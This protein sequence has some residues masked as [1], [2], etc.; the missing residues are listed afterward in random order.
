MGRELIVVLLIFCVL[1]L[2]LTH[3][4]TFS[5]SYPYSAL[6]LNTSQ[7]I[8]LNLSPYSN[9]TFS[10]VNCMGITTGPSY[11]INNLNSSVLTNITVNISLTESFVPGQY[12]EVIQYFKETLPGELIISQDLVGNITFL[13][14]IYNETPPVSKSKIVFMNP[15]N[16]ALY[17]IN[18]A[19]PL[20]I[21]F[22]HDTPINFSLT[23]VVLFL[24]GE[25]VNY[26][27]LSYSAA[28]KR[29]TV[30][31]LERLPEGI[32]T[33]YIIIADSDN[34]KAQPF[35]FKITVDRT[36]PLYPLS[37]S[38]NNQVFTNQHIDLVVTHNSTEYE[39]WYLI[40]R[41]R[42]VSALDTRWIL[43]NKQGTLA[44][45]NDIDMLRQ[46]I[47]NL[48]IKIRDKAANEAVYL[49]GIISQPSMRVTWDTSGKSAQ[50]GD[51]VRIGLTVQAKQGGPRYFRLKMSNFKGP[52]L[53]EWSILNTA[54][55]ESSGV[56]R[57]V[58]PNFWNDMPMDVGDDYT[59]EYVLKL[60]VPVNAVPGYDYFSDFSFQYTSVNNTLTNT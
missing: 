41:D 38:P 23:E 8:A 12:S 42:P 1:F 16:N 55:L 7:D 6:P 19:T 40:T 51:E 58:Q 53:L 32:T 10:C 26:S 52:D 15:L 46:P 5:Y 45:E 29:I 9:Y 50:P 25:P 49:T 39:T 4:E 44:Y 14:D 3:G 34:V 47:G 11:L 36:P 21:L 24:D 43:M 28:D 2:P 27:N 20:Q 35:D 56:V 48:W 30:N 17:G 18:T 59:Q 60:F 31:L 33:G 57:K 13:F 22:W 37:I 54:S